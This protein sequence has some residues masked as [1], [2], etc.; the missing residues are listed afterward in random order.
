MSENLELEKQLKLVA[1]TGSYIVGR[2]EVSTALK[3]AKLLVWSASA[4]VPQPILDECRSLS[5]PAI[6]F[7]GNPVELGRACGIPFRVS[8]IALKSAGDADLS[9][10]T[11]SSDYFSGVPGVTPAPSQQQQKRPEVKGTKGESE[12][13]PKKEAKKKE[14][15][16]AEKPKRAKKPASEEDE[17]EVKKTRK[18][19]DSEKS[20]PKKESKSEEK[21]TTTRKKKKS[22]DEDEEEDEK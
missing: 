20:S 10:F 15:A 8:V 11:S 6:K 16:K 7:S 14:T 22:T 13:K 18:K 12:A 5:I 9:G 3:G 21:K 2:R 19:S 17:G 4:N 1:K